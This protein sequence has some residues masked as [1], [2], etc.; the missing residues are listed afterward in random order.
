MTVYHKVRTK[1]S[2]EIS[3][4][5]KSYGAPSYLLDNHLLSVAKSD[6]SVLVVLQTMEDIGKIL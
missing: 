2:Y 1:N 5:K 3:R 6:Y 4:D